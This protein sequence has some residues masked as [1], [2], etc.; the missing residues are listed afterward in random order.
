MISLVTVKCALILTCKAMLSAHLIIFFDV[1]VSACLRLSR[2]CM[3]M[4]IAQTIVP[5]ERIQ[6]C[7]ETDARAESQIQLNAIAMSWLMRAWVMM[8]VAVGRL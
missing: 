5:L 6:T 7:R 2:D 8:A 3:S 4:D 1:R